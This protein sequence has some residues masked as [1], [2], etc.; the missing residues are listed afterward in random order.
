MIDG[1]FIGSTERKLDVARMRAVWENGPPLCAEALIEREVSAR[2]HRTTKR[3]CALAQL[4]SS[5]GLSD[6][7]LERIEATGRGA[8]AVY[9]WTRYGPQL[10]ERFGFMSARQLDTLISANDDAPNDGVR[11]KVVLNEMERIAASGWR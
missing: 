10:G 4:L 7:T 5:L 2:G 1:P 3:R 9:F 8:D 11:L 6:L